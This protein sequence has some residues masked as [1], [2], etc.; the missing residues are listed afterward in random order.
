[1]RITD[2]PMYS[3]EVESPSLGDAIIICNEMM[4][5]K[6]ANFFLEGININ[7]EKILRFVIGS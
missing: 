1:M 6:S 5:E 2:E 3:T 4:K 7:S